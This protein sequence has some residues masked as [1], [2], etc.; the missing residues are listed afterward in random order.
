MSDGSWVKKE[1]P[2][3]NNR[4]GSRGEDKKKCAAHLCFYRRTGGGARGEHWGW[5]AAGG[6]GELHTFAPCLPGIPGMPRSPCR[7]KQEK[8]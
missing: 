6:W 3:L 4:P 8:Q 1:H 5:G 2:C 7:K